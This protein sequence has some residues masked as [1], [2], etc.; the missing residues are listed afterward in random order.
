MLEK[1]RKSDVELL[2]DVGKFVVRDRAE[3]RWRCRKCGHEF[4][5]RYDSNFETRFGIPVRCPV[6]HPVSPG[7]SNEEKAFVDFVKGVYCGRLAENTKSVISPYELDLYLPDENLAFEFDGLFW[8]SEQA[9]KPKDYHLRKTEMCEK[10]GVRLVHVFENEW[11][12][13]KDIVKS[14]VKRMLRQCDRTIC[15]SE[16]DVRETISDESFTFQNENHIK[17]GA[18]TSAG[19]GLYFKDELVSLVALDQI[20]P[21]KWE[22]T[23][24]CD[25]LDVDVVGSFRRLLEYFENAFRP[26]SLVCRCDRRWPGGELRRNAGFDLAETS[27]PACWHFD[28]TCRLRLVDR[29]GAE[30]AKLDGKMRIFDC[31]SYVFEKKYPDSR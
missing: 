19:V 28:R 7:Y 22:L 12:S 9:G 4:V 26:R 24:F 20:Q 25:K 31:G 5:A 13:K 2:D 14:Y 3:Y 15:A 29:P 6:C 10:L 11:T 27:G 21:E 8:H 1:L 23:R 18:W 17:G 16:C 30:D